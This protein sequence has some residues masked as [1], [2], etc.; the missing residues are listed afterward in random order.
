MTPIVTT[1][2]I[3]VESALI[4]GLRPRRIDDQILIGKVVEDG[5]AVKLA[6]VAATA[7]LAI[8]GTA[9]EMAAADVPRPG[10]FQVRLI[11]ALDEIDAGDLRRGARVDETR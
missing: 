3:S 7:G 6:M 5:P 9:G 4:S 11:D 1:P 10:T 2:I 8:F